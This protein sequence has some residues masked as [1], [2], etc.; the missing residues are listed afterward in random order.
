MD[1]V[2]GV[3]AQ[4]A[5]NM[6]D[7]GDWVTA[8][9]DGVP[10]LEKAPLPYWMI[11]VSYMMFGVHDWAARLP[12]A[13]AAILLCWLTARI[14]QWAFGRTAGMYAGLCLATSIGLFLFTRF[15]IPDAIL[16]LA[17][18]A[19]MWSLIRLLDDG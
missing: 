14:G 4:I 3:Q 7:S 2:D 19:G 6:L 11:A 13:L 8:H 17:I 15:L 16:T 12:V 18:T 1:D 9:L 5:R 10:Y